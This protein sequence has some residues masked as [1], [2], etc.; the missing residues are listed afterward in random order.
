MFDMLDTW[1]PY[2][3]RAVRVADDA[4][5]R[6]IAQ[7]DIIFDSEYFLSVVRQLLLDFEHYAAVQQTLV[8]LYNFWTVFRT[9]KASQAV[10]KCAFVFCDP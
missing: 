6:S 5:P 8:L 9:E 1:M 2:V 4:T 10:L 3:I 7:A